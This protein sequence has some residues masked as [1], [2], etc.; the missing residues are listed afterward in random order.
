MET[1]EAMETGLRETRGEQELWWQTHVVCHEL[2]QRMP[3]QF[4]RSLPQTPTLLGEL[5]TTPRKTFYLLALAQRTNG[6]RLTYGNT[7]ENMG[8]VEWWG[9]VGVLA[10]Y[11]KDATQQLLLKPVPN[12]KVY[13]RCSVKSRAQLLGGI[14]TACKL[15]IKLI[16]CTVLLVLSFI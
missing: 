15:T 11:S 10:I 9:G 4:W 16:F 6:E 7:K 12:S 2:T 5:Q 1:S 8:A 3:N 13:E 14:W